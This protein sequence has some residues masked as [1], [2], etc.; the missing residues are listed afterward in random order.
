MADQQTPNQAKVSDALIAAG[1]VVPFEQLK[2]TDFPLETRL[3]GLRALLDAM[4]RLRE[5]RRMEAQIEAAQAVEL[6]AA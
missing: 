5:R 3:R 2:W 1:V 6:K 4:A